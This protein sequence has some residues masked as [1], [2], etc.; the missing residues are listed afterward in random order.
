MDDKREIILEEEENYV[1]NYYLK[2]YIS[3]WSFVLRPKII[4]F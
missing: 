3:Q 2:I 4:D 1:L